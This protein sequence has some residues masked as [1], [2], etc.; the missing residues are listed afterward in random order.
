M[1]RDSRRYKKILVYSMSLIQTLPMS[2]VN[3][4]L[5]FTPIKRPEYELVL[6]E[7]ME[8]FNTEAYMIKR[9]IA[10]LTEVIKY[11]ML[12]SKYIVIEL[13]EQEAVYEKT[14]KEAY[15]KVIDKYASVLCMAESLKRAEL[16][17]IDYQ[18]HLAHTDHSYYSKPTV[19]RHLRK[20]NIDDIKRNPD[21]L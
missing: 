14:K 11:Q 8:Y 4:I 6:S 1:W 17:V 7:M 13:K 18:N 20:R 16:C 5:A 3:H 21:V 12:Y 19:L 2:V 10:L 9:Y 15:E